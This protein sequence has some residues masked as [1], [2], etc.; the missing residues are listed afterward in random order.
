VQIQ[1]VKFSFLMQ[2]I[3]NFGDLLHIDDT[4]AMNIRPSGGSV[5]RTSGII[6]EIAGD[7]L[8]LQTSDSSEFIVTIEDEGISSIVGEIILADGNTFF[9]RTFAVLH[10]RGGLWE[11]RDGKSRGE[12]YSF[13]VNLSDIYTGSLDDLLPIAYEDK[14]TLKITG[15]V[16]REIEHFTGV[17]VQHLPFNWWEN[18]EDWTFLGGTLS[19]TSDYYPIPKGDFSME[20]SFGSGGVDLSELKDGEIILQFV[21]E[22]YSE[23]DDNPEWNKDTGKRIPSDNIPWTTIWATVRNLTIELVQDEE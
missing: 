14:A 8:R 20:I 6:S 7:T 21:N 22:L 15:N 16:D 9:V 4:F 10:F 1:V 23:H 3:P 5:V 12:N 17:G 18:D 11:S 19:E 2:I 13:Y